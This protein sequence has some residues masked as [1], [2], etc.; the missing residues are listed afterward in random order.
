MSENEYIITDYKSA[1]ESFKKR[2]L[3]EKKSILRLDDNNEI[4][5][6]KNV[7]YLM[8]NFVNK[9]YSGDASFEDK[10][11]HQLDL[12]NNSDLDLKKGA[13]EVLATAVWLW[14]LPPSNAKD[15]ETSVKAI[16]KLSSNNFEI[17]ERNPFFNNFL[18]FASTGTYYNTNKPFELAYIINFLNKV[19]DNLESSKYLSIL[20]SDDFDGK[21]TI[22]TESDY[23]KK[24][25]KPLEFIISK[26]SDKDKPRTVSIH[27]AL[28]HLFDGEKYEP[29][30]SN[31]HK[32]KI[33]KS[34][35]KIFNL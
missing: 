17:A 33:S 9:G 29:I 31:D 25:D 10:L 4:L 12:D 6:K 20:K 7:G 27:N 14:R 18:G 8:K 16:L 19:L 2:F 28:L 34:F 23:S 1:F 15:R 30:L 26:K 11:R 35:S 24:K 3:K 21:M 5:T 22:T 13:L 32:E